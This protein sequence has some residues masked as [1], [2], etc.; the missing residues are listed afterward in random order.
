MRE[1]INNYL[2]GSS[3]AQEKAAGNELLGKMAA[4]DPGF[5]KKVIDGDGRI[6][7]GLSMGN[8][9]RWTKFLR[10]GRKATFLYQSE[11]LRSFEA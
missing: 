4:A 1:I 10:N 5:M 6:G 11:T 2:S 3:G 9:G 8:T 7:K